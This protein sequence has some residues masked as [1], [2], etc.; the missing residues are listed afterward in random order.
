MPFNFQ[1]FCDYC[2]QTISNNGA[3]QLNFDSVLCMSPERLDLQV[4][5][6]PFEKQFYL[7][8]VF[9]QQCYFICR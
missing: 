5:F 6:Y 2:H 4:L 1:L 8:S 9:V 3:V 7:P